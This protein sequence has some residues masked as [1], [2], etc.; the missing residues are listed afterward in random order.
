M[1]VISQLFGVALVFLFCICY[2]WCTL[3]NKKKNCLLALYLPG[4]EGNEKV[5]FSNRS[6]L[7]A[8]RLVCGNT[9]PS[10]LNL[11]LVDWWVILWCLSACREEEEEEDEWG[12]ELGRRSRGA[13]VLLSQNGSGEE[14]QRLHNT[15]RWCVCVRDRYMKDEEDTWD[16]SR[17]S[18]LL[19]S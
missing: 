18:G 9:T 6:P 19:A 3:Y 16:E 12:R 8:S 17:S 14:V 13:V 11:T 5:V 15:D 7:V 4:K 2:T 1:A 10:G